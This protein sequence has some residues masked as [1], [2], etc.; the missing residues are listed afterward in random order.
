MTGDAYWRRIGNGFVLVWRIVGNPRRGPS[1]SAS[2]GFQRR[3]RDLV[4]AF[5]LGRQGDAARTLLLALRTPE[6]FP[7]ASLGRCLSV[8]SSPWS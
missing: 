5:P 1:L 2:G 6:W 4:P 7:R 8:L 3:V